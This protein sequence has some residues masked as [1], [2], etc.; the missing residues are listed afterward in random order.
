MRERERER[1]KK[2]AGEHLIRDGTAMDTGRKQR[3]KLH[4]VGNKIRKQNI[5]EMRDCGPFG[6]QRALAP[7]GVYGTQSMSEMS[8]NIHPNKP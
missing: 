2:L 1:G 7:A 8:S 5:A 6:L 3:I 4:V